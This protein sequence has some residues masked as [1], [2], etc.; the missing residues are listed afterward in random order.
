MVSFY[1]PWSKL[2]QPQPHSDSLKIELEC[3]IFK[4]VEA[5]KPDMT[6]VKVRMPDAYMYGS[7]MMSATQT[8][9]CVRGYTT[10]SSAI[11]FIGFEVFRSRF[12]D[13]LP[14]S[15]LSLPLRV[16]SAVASLPVA[17]WKVLT[18]LSPAWLLSDRASVSLACHQA[19]FKSGILFPKFRAI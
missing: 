10:F 1:V 16:L 9:I 14:I 11:I 19:A 17:H 13:F 18:F 15:W 12:L 6:S 8:R 3:P 4:L 7:L 2:C 5:Q